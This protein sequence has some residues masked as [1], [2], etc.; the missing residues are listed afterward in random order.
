MAEEFKDLFVNTTGV[1]TTYHEPKSPTHPDTVV[2][3]LTDSAKDALIKGHS[4]D[5]AQLGIG[6]DSDFAIRL[7]QAMAQDLQSELVKS[8]KE[9]YI[10]VWEGNKTPVGAQVAGHTIGRTQ[11]GEMVSDKGEFL[12]TYTR[13]LENGGDSKKKQQMSAFLTAKPA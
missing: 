13:L 3:K 5:G 2:A 7:T 1:R 4:I 11:N 8:A 9:A 12:G 10:L 6:N